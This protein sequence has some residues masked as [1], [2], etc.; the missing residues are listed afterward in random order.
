V[1]EIRYCRLWPSP[2]LQHVQTVGTGQGPTLSLQGDNWTQ[3]A[4]LPQSV[5][6]GTSQYVIRVQG[7]IGN[8]TYVGSGGQRGMMQVCLGTVGGTKHP[9]FVANVTITE[10]LS[11]TNGIP[12]EFLVFITS[13]LPDDLFG[14]SL[15]PSTTQLCLWARTFTNGDT[16]TYAVEFDVADVNWLW[17]DVGSIPAGHWAAEEFTTGLGVN[18]APPAGFTKLGAAFGAPGQTW[19]S[20]CNVLYQSVTYQAPA[21]V[22]R[23][24]VT[25]DG[26]YGAFVVKTGNAGRWGMSRFPFGVSTS[27]L[28]PPLTSQGT[29]FVHAGLQQVGYDS[30]TLPPHGPPTVRRYRHFTVRVDT[31]PDFRS[32]TEAGPFEMGQTIGFPL[33]WWTYDLVIE[34]PAPSPGILTRCVVLAQATI[35]EANQLAG[36]GLRVF[37]GNDPEAG[38]GEFACFSEHDA[39]RNE[40]VSS[41]AAGFRTFQ[42][43]SPAMQ[44][45]VAA[46][47]DNTVAPPGPQH[48]FDFCFVMF[49]PVR[50]P[51][52]V[53]T[54]PG[55]LPSPLLLVPG[56]QSPDAG[57][58]SLPPFPPNANPLERG[59]LERHQIRGATG[60][61]RGWPMGAKAL[62]VFTVSWGPLAEADAETLYDFL[63]ANPA[64][65]YVAPRS[66]ALAV[67]GLNQPELQ[68]SSHRTFAIT[69][70]VAVLVWTG[71]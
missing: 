53:T 4:A 68:P 60:Y 42:T 28:Q 25:P 13:T 2:P 56:K 67:L 59:N 52:S 16:Q 51:E 35:S 37:E 44:F 49:H 31:L 22:F 5:M 64:W 36:Y 23:F 15:N 45:R 43:T 12:F 21:P 9:S 19:L 34:R 66:A 54:P 20:F 62:R 8:R 71:A 26:T 17:W 38:F 24:G 11:A 27:L 47:G 48:G 41:M 10:A 14:S 50:D 46:P 65:R 61:T 1:T 39:L 58:L 32:R 33:T 29:F 70:D 3:L 7:K 63:V 57:S 55:S 18:P 40:A 30:A 6:A 69:Q